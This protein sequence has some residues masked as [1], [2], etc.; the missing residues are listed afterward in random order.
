MGSPIDNCMISHKHY[1]FLNF[2]NLDFGF[3]SLL[4]SCSCLTVYL[5][6]FS[7][8][9]EPSLRGKGAMTALA[10]LG[11]TGASWG[12]GFPLSA[13]CQGALTEGDESP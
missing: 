7:G 1:I 4:I 8:M 9:W 6:L 3:W 11:C 5:F 2:G 13:L 12:F 10:S